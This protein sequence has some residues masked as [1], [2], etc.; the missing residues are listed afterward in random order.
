[1]KYAGVDKSYTPITELLHIPSVGQLADTTNG[2]RRNDKADIWT[3]RSRRIRELFLLRVATSVA[4]PI[5]APRGNGTV[6]PAQH[7]PCSALDPLASG[8]SRI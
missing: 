6:A 5:N 2:G 8:S 4:R 7:G 3:Q 1:M